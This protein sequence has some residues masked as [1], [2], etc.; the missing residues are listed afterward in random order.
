MAS[1][2]QKTSDKEIWNRRRGQS[3]GGETACVTQSLTKDVRFTFKGSN[4]NRSF[5]SC[6]DLNSS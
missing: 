3:L 4:C 2:L 5:N 1:K 6:R